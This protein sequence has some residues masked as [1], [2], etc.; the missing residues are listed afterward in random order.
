MDAGVAGREGGSQEGKKA[1]ESP[2]G[3][4]SGVNSSRHDLRIPGHHCTSLRRTVIK[5]E[6]SRQCD[7]MRYS[8]K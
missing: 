6:F 8:I 1:K 5:T 3:F 2:R 4:S 7:N